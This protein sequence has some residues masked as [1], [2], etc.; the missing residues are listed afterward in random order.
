M[1][2]FEEIFNK[3]SCFI[4]EG[5]LGL[6]LQRECGLQPDTNAA[7]A[8]T[9]RSERGRAALNTLW[10]EYYG[11]ASDFGLPFLAATPTRRLDSARAAAGGL[12]RE[13]I[14]ENLDFMRGVLR[15]AQHDAKKNEHRVGEDISVK[16]C[17]V[18]GEGKPS[19][20]FAGGTVCCFVD[21]YTGRGCLECGESEKY[22][23]W[24]IEAFARAGA[25]YILAALQPSAA[26]AAGIARCAQAA[27]LPVI[28][29]FCIDDNGSLPCGESINDAIEFTDRVSGNAPLCYMANCVHPDTLFR[30]LMPEQNRTETVKRRFMGLQANAS[31]LPHALL[32]GSQSVQSSSP[33][34]LAQGMSRLQK[35]ISMKLW[36]GCCGTNGEHMKSI[37]A[38]AVQ[39]YRAQR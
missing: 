1:T 14:A 2:A 36:G 25:D 16:P 20:W 12:G 17:A 22:H 37:A 3:E 10:R 8:L 18:C 23:A 39:Y 27:G 31:P 34:Q 35:I 6:R 29:S 4:M 33:E 24:E 26:E 30:A 28:I 21:A 38:A 11:I 5:A 9:V 19:E 7:L 15:R 32:E 13:L